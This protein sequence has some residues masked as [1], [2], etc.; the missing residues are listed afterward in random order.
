MNPG[1]EFR[2]LLVD[3]DESV[4]RGLQNV[5]R[6]DRRRWSTRIAGGASAALEE[7]AREPA[8]VVVSDLRMPGVDGIE[9]LGQVLDRWPATARVLLSGWS[10]AESIT[11]ALTVAHRYLLKPCD[12]ETL[13]LELA[14][15]EEIQASLPQP[16][17]RAALGSLRS[18]PVSP[19]TLEA[20]RQVP[21]D[22]TPR[23]LAVG[24][25]VHGDVALAVRVLQFV[26]SPSFGSPRPVTGLDA[27]LDLTGPGLLRE[28]ASALEPP[29]PASQR[30]G[31][32]GALER[33]QRHAGTAAR[34]ARLLA[35]DPA[36]ADA[37]GTAALLHD[38][39]RFALLASLPDA[40]ASILERVSR[41]GRDLDAV[42]RD[43]L[44]ASHARIGAYLLGLW[45][46]PPT[47]VDAVAR[48]HDE[49]VLMDGG[50][51]GLVAAANLLAHRADA[52]SR[53]SPGT[54]SPRS[55]P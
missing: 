47:L 37:A 43:V 4:V 24:A 3:D 55:L 20:L 26:S 51:P 2:I 12:A 50:L 19:T 40:Y 45:G 6:P 8:D 9:L 11:R 52:P 5:L 54:D 33:L 38:A 28:I 17:L 22:A 49:G 46:L 14:G 32:A 31:S 34:M 35:P 7:M 15:I 48:H 39:G 41:S 29:P 18:L 53:A 27:A 1:P 36:G 13:R 16:G 25:A 42:E 21:D 44:S 30:P 10:D 23:A